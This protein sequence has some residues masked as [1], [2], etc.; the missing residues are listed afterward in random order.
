MITSWGGALR[1]GAQSSIIAGGLLWLMSMP[2][3]AA[4]P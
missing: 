3:A 2:L 4:T 1:A